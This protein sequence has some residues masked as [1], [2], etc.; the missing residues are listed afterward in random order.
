MSCHLC[1]FCDE[2]GI[3]LETVFVIVIFLTLLSETIQEKIKNHHR[4]VGSCL[5]ST[6]SRHVRSTQ[7]EQINIH[8]VAWVSNKYLKITEFEGTEVS[9]NQIL[10]CSLPMGSRGA[11]ILLSLQIGHG[12]TDRR[13]CVTL[14]K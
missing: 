3:S 11:P 4:F 7:K 13:P 10:C 12:W 5:V 9:P 6:V 14:W 2:K 8:M 1:A